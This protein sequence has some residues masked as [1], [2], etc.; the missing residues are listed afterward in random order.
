M[1]PRA[2]TMNQR[3]GT[4]FATACSGADM[5]AIGNTI[6]DRMVLGSIVAMMAVSIAARCEVVLDATSTPMASDTSE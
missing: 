5:L 4:M 3:A 6:P 2:M 1:M